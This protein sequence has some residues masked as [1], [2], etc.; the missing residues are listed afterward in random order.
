[1]HAP[2]VESDVHETRAEDMGDD[3]QFRVRGVQPLSVGKRL[4]VRSSVGWAICYLASILPQ[5]RY[6][7][8]KVDSSSGP[9]ESDIRGRFK[10]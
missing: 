6:A 2:E 9:Y 7:R 10:T 3:G 5:Q 8:N 4:Q 1:M